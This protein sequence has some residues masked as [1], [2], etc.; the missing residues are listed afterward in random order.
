M[1]G[2]EEEKD[3]VNRMLN[4]C[5]EFERIAKVVLDKVEKETS[6][7]RKRKGNNDQGAA[8][9]N[10]PASR[11][12]AQN[13]PMAGHK[14]PQFSNTPSSL[15]SH[16]TDQTGYTSMA[17]GLSPGSWMAETG[18]PDGS[19]YLTPRSGVPFTDSANS[20]IN[21]TLNLG[22]FQQPFVPQ[23]LWQMPMTLEWDW[24]NMTG[25]G[26]S[27]F[28]NGMLEDPNLFVNIGQQ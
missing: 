23:D 1:L 8:P 18:F 10:A 5:T 11:L 26:Y 19:E 4:V 28:E 17:G 7:R 27:G 13:T 2:S 16:M 12:S 24:A 3:G 22:A 6:S 25:G 20:D 21:S 9:S 14:S 15:T